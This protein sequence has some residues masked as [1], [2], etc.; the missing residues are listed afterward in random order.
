MVPGGGRARPGERDHPQ[1]QRVRAGRD[2]ERLHRVYYEALATC[3]ARAT[4]R[5]CRVLQARTELRTLRDLLRFAVSRFNE[6]GLAFGH[7]TDNA[8]DEA[9]YLI[10]HTLHLPLDR[11]EPFLDARLTRA[12]MGRVLDLVERRVRGA[13]PRRLSHARSLARRIP[14]LRRPA[15]DR[16]AVVHRRAHPRATSR[17][18]CP[19]RDRYPRLDLC[20]GSGCLAMLLAPVSRTPRST[21]PTSPPGARGRRA[22]RARLRT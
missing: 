10:L 13:Q 20:T 17:R 6:A 9:A 18:G 4:E 14:L 22:Q 15:G 16:A 21:P 7:G 8:Y 12:E 1:A 2:V 3:S 5:A 19:E 11:L